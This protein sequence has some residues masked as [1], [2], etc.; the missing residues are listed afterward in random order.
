[1]LWVVV[2]FSSPLGSP[3]PFSFY[4]LSWLPSLGGN[5]AFNTSP[6]PHSCS[7][8]MWWVILPFSRNLTQQIGHMNGCSPVC[9]L[10]CLSNLEGVTKAL[11]HTEHTFFPRY[12]V[13]VWLG[14][15]VW[16][17]NVS[18]FIKVGRSGV[19]MLPCKNQKR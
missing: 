3:C 15:T 7:L 17:N 4:K 12:T 18:G 8:R 5:P 16:L 19:G 14:W 13:L 2:N 11:P 9:V 1:M 10:M 6:G